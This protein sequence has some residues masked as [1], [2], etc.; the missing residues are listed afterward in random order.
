M[1]IV[2]NRQFTLLKLHEN[3]IKFIQKRIENAPTRRQDLTGRLLYHYGS[4]QATGNAYHKRKLEETVIE[5]VTEVVTEGITDHRV[6]RESLLLDIYRQKTITQLL[7]ERLTILNN[8]LINKAIAWIESNTFTGWYS[9]AI[10]GS[11]FSQK[12][13]QVPEKTYLQHLITL[14]REAEK[15]QPADTLFSQSLAFG[16]LTSL[17]FEGIAGFLLMLITIESTMNEEA[18]KRIVQQGIRFILSFKKEVDFSH[19]KYSVFPSAINAKK[20]PI[21]GS[22]YL[23][24]SS[25]DLPQAFLLYK[26][27]PF[28]QDKQLK[29]MADLVGLNTLLR[30]GTEHTLVSGEV[31]YGGSSGIAQVYDALFRL[32]KYKAYH[33]G[34]T[35]WTQQTLASIDKPLYDKKY[36]GH[37][38]SLLHG[39]VG[40]YLALLTDTKKGKD[41]QRVLLF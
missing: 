1:V 32:S 11:Y 20:E 39:L 19:Q 14:W 17:G 26:A 33:K 22:D 2:Q 41:W 8:Y 16:D 34:Y 6:L 4:Y 13:D 30:K 3:H 40:I 5:V 12:A 37:E 23:S 36:H 9:A 7:S 10:V 18:L 21:I 35:F 29:K 38:Y 31:L 25:G 27:S 24:W 28:F 15:S